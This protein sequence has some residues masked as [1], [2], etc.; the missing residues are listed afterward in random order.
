MNKLAGL[1]G[2]LAMV[3][4]A[5]LAQADIQILVNGVACTPTTG[6]NP[7]LDP[8]ANGSLTCSAI[9]VAPGV[10][11]SDLAVV[12]LQ[13]GVVAQQF[14]TT[15][16]VENTTASAATITID[17]GVSNYT[18][19]NP[20][21]ADSSGSTINGTIGTNSVTL[22]SCVDQSNGLSGCA[23]PTPGMAGPNGTL[24]VTGANTA[25]NES[26]GSITSLP[27]LFS[28]TQHIVLSAGADGN[29][30]YTTSQVLTGTPVVVTACPMSP[31]F[32]KKHPFPAAMTFPV[33]IGGISYS[34]ADFHTILDNPGG[35]N[36]LH[37]LGF[38]LVAA[39]LNA[40]N[41]A[42]VPANVA[43]TILHAGSLLAGPPALN[44][45]TDFVAPSSTLGGLMVADAA[46]LDTFNNTENCTL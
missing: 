26:P 46:V 7:L 2:V 1:L 35:G 27:A 22:T 24:T 6:T 18:S 44:M 17:I 20:P 14:G 45:V 29:F 19:L 37:I 9:T 12:G 23:T 38:Q 32:W 25:V 16:L 11:I 30:N 43:A 39:L 33:T 4:V 34:E 3:A 41:G 21:I 40:A 10:T 42:A 28:L 36:A 31:G 5:P 13:V 15:L 8:N